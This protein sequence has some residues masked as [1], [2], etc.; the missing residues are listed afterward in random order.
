VGTPNPQPSALA[1]HHLTPIQERF[2]RYIPV[3]SSSSG[4]TNEFTYLTKP[5]S[6]GGAT[7]KKIGE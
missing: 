7:G 4:S 5:T 1:I 3:D 2:F 6:G